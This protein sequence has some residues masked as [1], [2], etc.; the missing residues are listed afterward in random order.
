MVL[1][2][3]MFASSFQSE[4]FIVEHGVLTREK[5]SPLGKRADRFVLV[6][7][8]VEGRVDEGLRGGTSGAVMLLKRGTQTVVLQLAVP[9]AWREEDRRRVY[10][11]VAALVAALV[12][13][14]AAPAGSTHNPLRG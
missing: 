11:D 5:A 1:G 6:E 12:K 8:E 7:V 14:G 9:A 10:A 2:V 3:G 4:R 13:L